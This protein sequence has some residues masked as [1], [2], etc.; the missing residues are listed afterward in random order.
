[1]PLPTSFETT[2]DCVL[3]KYNNGV[4][5]PCSGHGECLLGVCVCDKYWSGRSDWTSLDGLDCQYND[6]AVRLLWAIVLALTLNSLLQGSKVMKGEV[7]A[8]KGNVKAM[9]GRGSGKFCL[10]GLFQSTLM[11]IVAIAKVATNMRIDPVDGPVI[12]AIYIVC[13]ISF[14]WVSIFAT[15]LQLNLALKGMNAKKGGSDM[16]KIAKV[17]RLANVKGESL[18]AVERR[19][20]Y[21]RPFIYNSL[22]LT[23]RENVKLTS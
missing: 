22:Q 7:A 13:S 14:Y 8:T 11:A 19:I 10:V 23:S 17:M 2:E 16:D 1:M 18:L 3:S 4:L 12:Y 15:T 21:H 20:F 6:V 9:W 5:G